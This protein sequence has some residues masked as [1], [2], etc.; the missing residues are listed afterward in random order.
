M[1]EIVEVALYELRHNFGMRLVVGNL[2]LQTFTNIMRAN[3]SRLKAL[4]RLEQP[5]GTRI[6][7][8]APKRHHADI[9]NEGTLPALAAQV[10]QLAGVDHADE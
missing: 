5:F 2:K 10:L 3:A 9:T 6:F 4:Q 1:G 7:D 8:I